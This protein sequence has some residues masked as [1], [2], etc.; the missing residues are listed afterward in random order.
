MSLS[1]EWRCPFSRGN[2]YKD[3]GNIFRG[4]DLVSPEL[5]CPL[6]RGVPKE[7]SHCIL[8]KFA[9]R[10]GP[11][12]FSNCTASQAVLTLLSLRIN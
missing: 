5:R 4:T 7:R 9:S 8:N 11:P 12:L 2:K 10:F 3:Y 1:P 6:N